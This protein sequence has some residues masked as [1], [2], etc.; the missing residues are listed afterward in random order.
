MSARDALELATRGGAA[1]L[2]RSGEIGQLSVGAC[3]DL[4]VWPL[5]GV[6]F[7]GAL[8]DPVEAWLRCGPVAARHTV[9]AGRP[10]VE[11]GVPVHPGLDEQLAAHRRISARMQEL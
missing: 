4:V 10:V 11:D 7:A 6:A 8:S 1:V 2:G 3:G 9:V 5:T